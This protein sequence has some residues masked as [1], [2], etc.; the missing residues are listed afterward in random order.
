MVTCTRP[1]QDQV[2][3]D[4]GGR[5]HEPPHL[6]P[7][8]VV[9]ELLRRW[10]AGGSQT[11]Y[12]VRLVSREVHMREKSVKITGTRYKHFIFL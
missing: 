9:I 10:M 5:A 7:V 6:A 12:V 3:I 11:E 8:L 4:R 2:S 1:A